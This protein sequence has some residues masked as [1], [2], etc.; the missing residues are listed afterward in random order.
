M[1]MLVAWVLFPLLFAA[2]SLGCGLLVEE[3]AGGTLPG[4]LLLPTGFAAIVVAS[5]FTTLSSSTAPLT[6]PLVIALAIAGYGLAFPSKHRVDR[7]C[8]VAALAVF[9]VY[10]T[11]IVLSGAATFAGYISLDDTATW[12]ALADNALVH[13]RSVAGLAPSTYS[14]VLHDNLS[15]YPIGAFLSLG[16]GRQ[17]TGTDAAWLFQ[18]LIAYLGVLLG[19]CVYQ[20]VGG[21]IA[22][23]PLRALT[24]FISA[25]PAILYGYAFWSGI[26][27]VTAAVLVALVAGLAHEAAGGRRLR[28]FL[29][30]AVAAA[31]MLDVLAVVGGVWLAALAVVL[32]VAAVRAGRPGPTLGAFGVALALSLPALLLARAFLSSTFGGSITSGGTLANLYHPLS[33]LQIFGLWPV[34]DF[35]LRPA[36]MA[37][38]Y[39]FVALAAAAGLTA[40]ATAWRRT[41][42]RGLPLYVIASIG[43]ALLVYF[44]DWIGHGSPWLDGKA[45]AE[46]SPAM[47]AAAVAG[48]AWLVEHPRGRE[49]G[50][51]ALVV[52]CGGVLWSNA[53]TY[54]AVWLAPHAQLAEL[55]TIGNRFAGDGPTLM[56]EQQPYGVRHFLRR[57]D[58]EGASERRARIVALRAGGSLQPLTYADLDLFTL[59][60]V[61]VYRTIVLRTSPI[62]SRPPS[63]YRLV[64]R[65]RWYEVWQRPVNVPAT[66][67]DHLSLGSADQAVAVPAC[68]TVLGVAAEVPP[69]GRLVAALH[70]PAARVDLGL[71]PHP[72]RWQP[73]GDGAIVPHGG[74]TIA[75]TVRLARSATYGFWLGG[76]VPDRVSLTVDGVPVGSAQSVLEWSPHQMPLGSLRL[77]AGPHRVELTYA[78]IGLGPGRHA[79]ELGFGPLEIGQSDADTR[80]VTVAPA[81]AKSLCGRSLDWLEAVAG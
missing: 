35:R 16:I 6:S 40:V 24:A 42:H 37:L 72:V 63:I 55:E 75:A 2:L 76:S 22:S 9:A 47:L 61:T 50:A 36:H 10:A 66:I 17:L 51:V 31:A 73:V 70:M 4:A 30:A 5:S 39:L 59:G 1:T 32:I 60:A 41:Q 20:L 7:W 26:K 38:T 67:V 27:E 45:L 81:D 49:L 11:P 56:T 44:T 34:E 14:V 12:L 62:E 48:G 77:T 3:I 80:I 43:G 18:P 53:L 65:G 69:G 29:P 15:Q 46:A 8:A 52:V 25:Q 79:G 28:A 19:L 74:G 68:S 64:W 54:G 78:A 23:R 71:L 57:L 13:G 33:K 58:A 21:L